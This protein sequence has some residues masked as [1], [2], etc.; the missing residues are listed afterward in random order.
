MLPETEIVPGHG[1]MRID[2][3][4]RAALA[5]RYWSHHIPAR[6]ALGAWVFH[7]L[8]NDRRCQACHGSWPCA[9]RLWAQ[10]VRDERLSRPVTGHPP[11]PTTVPGQSP[12]PGTAKHD[13]L[14]PPAVAEGATA[15]CGRVSPAAAGSGNPA[16][17][18]VTGEAD[19]DTRLPGDPP[20]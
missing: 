12:P 8:N 14:P 6:R 19:P 1:R 20:N 15:A 5:D 16:P 2:D 7:P 17:P 10:Q 4:A 3:P 9:A 18:H 11:K 13:R